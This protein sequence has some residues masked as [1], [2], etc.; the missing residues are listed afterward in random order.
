MLRSMTAYG[1]ASLNTK[2]GHFV[3]EIQSVNRKFLDVSVILPQELS[4]FDIEIKKWILP[5]VVR[6]QVNVKVSATF[7]GAAPFIIRPNLPLARQLKAYIWKSKNFSFLFLENT[8]DFS[9]WK[10]TTNMKRFIG[11]L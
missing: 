8:P 11:K 4:Q 10:K 2:V 9:A 3:I 7:E 5:H 1:R 6:G